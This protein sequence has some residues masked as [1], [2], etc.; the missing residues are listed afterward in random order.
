VV[1]TRPKRYG[2][3]AESFETHVDPADEEHLSERFARSI[4]GGG[5][6]EQKR[7]WQLFEARYP[8]AN[9]ANAEGLPTGQD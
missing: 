4:F 3:S 8:L 5:K 2:S 1:T 6:D 9:D 7:P